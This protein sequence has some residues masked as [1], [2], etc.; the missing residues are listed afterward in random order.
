MT[1]AK[2][3]IGAW[4]LAILALVVYYFLDPGQNELFPRCPFYSC[5]GLKCPGCGS[6]RALH[7]LLHFRI[8]QAFAENPLL[9]IS[10]PYLLFSLF[11]FL[12]KRKGKAL[13]F[14]ESILFQG[15]ASKV[16]LIIVLSFFLLRN[17]I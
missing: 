6:Q 8:G 10:I 12:I 14:W 16:V 11:L 7:A 4:M 1:S 2:W 3:Y 5:T 15:A 17:L 13:L 9:V